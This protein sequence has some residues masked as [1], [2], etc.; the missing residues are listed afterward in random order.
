MTALSPRAAA[1]LLVAST[2]LWAGTS[3]AQ[4]VD[5]DRT[6]Q[7]GTSQ[8]GTPATSFIDTPDNSSQARLNRTMWPCA[9]STMIRLG[10]VSRMEDVADRLSMFATY[11][12]D[13]GRIN[14]QLGRYLAVDA[15]QVR[16]IDTSGEQFNGTGGL[17]LVEFAVSR[18]VLVAE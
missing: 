11:F 8:N 17:V 15:A 2:L 10:A 13:P 6:Q 18:S 4:T 14:G 1:G 3:A 5:R 16:E 9:S 7:N 12:D